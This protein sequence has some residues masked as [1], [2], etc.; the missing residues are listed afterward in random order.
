MQMLEDATDIVRRTTTSACR[1]IEVRKKRT[2]GTTDGA[3]NQTGPG[4]SAL[5]ALLDAISEQREV[6]ANQ[7]NVIC[8]LRDVVSKQ[9]TM[10]QDFHSQFQEHQRQMEGAIADTKAQLS[11]ELKQARDQIDTLMRNPG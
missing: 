9:Q 8:E 1:T 7:Q 3:D 5:Q 2:L 6:I 4:K 11:E 10:I